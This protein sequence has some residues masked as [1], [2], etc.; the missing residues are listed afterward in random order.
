IYPSGFMKISAL[1]IE[2]QRVRTLI[3]FDN[4]T[5]HLRPG[6]SLDVRIITGE[7]ENAAAVPERATFRHEG[8]WAVFT[9]KGGRAHLTPVTV[10]LKNDEWAEIAEGVV[11]GM[12][13]VADV[14]NELTDGMRVSQL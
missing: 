13:V 12:T 14:K 11:P 1:G 6:T 8:E 2:Q 9:V 3:S 10:G 5:L 7:S 4:S